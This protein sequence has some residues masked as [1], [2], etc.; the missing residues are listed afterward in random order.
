[1]TTKRK[2]LT[3]SRQPYK[4]MM[5]YDRFIGTLVLLF[6]QVCMLPSCDGQQQRQYSC[7]DLSDTNANY[8]WENWNFYEI[9]GLEDPPSS[10]KKSSSSKSRRKAQGQRQK[11]DAKDVKKAYRKQ[12]QQW[13]PDKISSS[14]SAPE[15]NITVEE[16]NA[17][18]AKIADA[19]SIL[20]N[21]ESKE[22]YDNYLKHCEEDRGQS[23]SSSSSSSNDNNSFEDWASSIFSKFTNGGQMRNPFELFEELVFGGGKGDGD[24]DDDYMFYDSYF[25]DADMANDY[26]YNRQQQYRGGSSG[27]QSSQ[28][29]Q[30][31][32]VAY[33]MYSGKECIRISKIEEYKIASNRQRQQRIF[34][35]VIVQDFS[36]VYDPYE[37]S[38]ALQAT[39][40]QPYILDE[41]WTTS[42]S[43]TSMASS[44][45]QSSNK[46]VLL[47]GMV[48]T[49][50]DSIVLRSPNGRYYSGLSSDCQLLTFAAMRGSSLFGEAAEEDEELIWRSNTMI[51]YHQ[52]Q[53]QQRKQHVDCFASLKDGHLIIA[54]G[55]SP[56]NMSS[57]LWYSNPDPQNS[58]GSSRS[59]RFRHGRDTSS[60]GPTYATQLD[61]DGSLVVYRIEI[62]IPSSR[63]N[64]DDDTGINVLLPNINDE[65]RNLLHQSREY[66]K[67][68]VIYKTCI[69]AT[70]PMGCN[71]LG[72]RLYQSIRDARY[73][74]LLAWKT[75]DHVI[76]R[77]VLWL[78]DQDE[79]D[80]YY[81]SGFFRSN[82]YY[83]DTDDRSVLDKVWGKIRRIQRET[84]TMARQSAEMFRERVLSRFS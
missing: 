78:A 15:T 45:S 51:P 17:R 36:Q 35:R 12:A 13:H 25:F 22:E 70:G 52:I 1:M 81:G 79:H 43:T 27:Q 55:T 11:F 32:S 48:V 6:T 24:D 14:S 44:M 23:S 3:N 2:P 77:F 67:Q 62:M 60:L 5:R 20:S 46:Y 21:V 68:F 49:H 64:D 41:G 73:T 56:D 58:N 82:Y 53:Q 80:E 57:L 30:T 4:A 84:S 28:S 40:A 26:G 16:S 69:H 63:G 75:I 72:R 10:N 54:G 9:L 31:Q 71:R 37:R 83:Q 61:N 18:F 65:I 8:E 50:D 76:D 59:G 33:D 47:P 66:S 74:V 34:Y 29:Y 42:S 38:M 39:T 19:Y 7:K